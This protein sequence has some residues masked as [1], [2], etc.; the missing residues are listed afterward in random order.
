VGEEET[1]YYYNQRSTT[2]I[3]T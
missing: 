1:L 3:R 2:S